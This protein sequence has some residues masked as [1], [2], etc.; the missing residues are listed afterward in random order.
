MKQLSSTVHGMFLAVLTTAL[1]VTSGEAQVIRQSYVGV[2]HADGWT[3]MFGLQ[4]LND[5]SVGE[6]DRVVDEGG[7]VLT[8]FAAA[9]LRTNPTD[10]TAH[11]GLGVL[12]PTGGELAYWG[13]VGLASVNPAGGGGG[14][15]LVGGF[16]AGLAWLTVG[17]IKLEGRSNPSLSLN[18]DLTPAFI[19]DATPIC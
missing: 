17:A 18:L 14:I 5:I 9:G 19:C 13:P 10:I 15:R 1:I 7:A 12:F 11:F 3:A 2:G 16:G 6:D 4:F 8:G